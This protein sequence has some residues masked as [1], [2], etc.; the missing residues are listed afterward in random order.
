MTILERAPFLAILAGLI[1]AMGLEKEV[2]P[3]LFPV[4]APLTAAGV[5]LCTFRK[6]R[7]GQWPLFVLVLL[8]IDSRLPASSLSL[9]SYIKPQWLPPR[10]LSTIAPRGTFFLC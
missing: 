8:L 1:A 2:G 10:A 5:L 7:R 9:P 4:L 3:V 6:E